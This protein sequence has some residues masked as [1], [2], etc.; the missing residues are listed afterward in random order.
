MKQQQQFLPGLFSYSLRYICHHQ[1]PTY[2]KKFRVGNMDFFF[3]WIQS[4]TV[5]VIKLLENC[6][7]FVCACFVESIKDEKSSSWDWFCTWSRENYLGVSQKVWVSHWNEY[8]CL[9]GPILKLFLK[10]FFKKGFSSFFRF[11]NFNE[12]KWSR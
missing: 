11:S 1:Q 6:W 12:R 10:F 3:H 4:W 8:H 7:H 2:P 5:F 9:F